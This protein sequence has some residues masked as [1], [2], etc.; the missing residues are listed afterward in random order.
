MAV[1]LRKRL[2]GG[3][4]RGGAAR[5]SQ[6]A[7]GADCFRLQAA[8]QTRSSQARS[9]PRARRVKVRAL[10]LGC[11]VEIP[12]PRWPFCVPEPQVPYL[13]SGDDSPDLTAIN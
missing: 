8:S 11:P 4:G 12:T 10:S 1:S 2:G 9:Q 3:G 13:Q 6:M 5:S 7:E